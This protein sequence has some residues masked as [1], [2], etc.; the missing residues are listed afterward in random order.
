MEEDEVRGGETP[1]A[2]WKVRKKKFWAKKKN[3][4]QGKKKIWVKKYIVLVLVWYQN[5]ALSRQ[6]IKEIISQ[7]PANTTAKSQQEFSLWFMNIFFLFLVGSYFVILL[8]YWQDVIC[9]IY[10]EFE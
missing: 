2:E 1:R 8:L 10:K 7:A 6:F 4:F 3:I 9:E 5:R